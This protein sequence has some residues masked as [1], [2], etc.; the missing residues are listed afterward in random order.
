M[1]RAITKFGHYNCDDH[2]SI[3]SVFP[4]FKLTLSHVSSLLPRVKMN[5]INWSAPNIW[6][7]TTQLEENCS[8]RA[9]AMGSNPVEVLKIF[10]GYNLQLLKH[11]AILY[12]EAKVFSLSITNINGRPMH[13]FDWLLH[14]GII[15][16]RCSLPLKFW[17]AKGVIFFFSFF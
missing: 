15:L 3:S 10:W 16:A 9:E 4:Q 17:K 13:P 1:K 8:A 6:V 2:T 5:S 7:F 12:N 11:G 14:S